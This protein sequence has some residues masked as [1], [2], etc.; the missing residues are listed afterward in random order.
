M[1]AASPDHPIAIAPAPGRIRVLV[2]GVIVAETTR[3]LV[4]RE[5]QLPPVHYIPR[6][7]V[8]MDLFERSERRTHCPYKGDATYYTVTAGGLVARH[9]AWSYEEPLA[10]VRQIAGHV[11]FH[12]E[13][14]DAVEELRA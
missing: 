2:G 13:K 12:R 7:D 3:A 9:A 11:A 6:E 14:V 8:Q 5:A 4:L 10:G 1:P